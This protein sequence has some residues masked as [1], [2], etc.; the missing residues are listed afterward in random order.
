V[1]WL[2]K[3]NHSIENILNNYRNKF[4][5][6]REINLVCSGPPCQGFSLAGLREFFDTW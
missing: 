2:E 4:K 3:E 6:L 1:D 5:S